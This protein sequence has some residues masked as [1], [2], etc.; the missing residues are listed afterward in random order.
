VTLHTPPTT[1][2]LGRMLSQW[3]EFTTSLRDEDIFEHLGTEEVVEA[4][5]GRSLLQEALDEGAEAEESAFYRRL[6]ISDRAFATHAPIV[7]QNTRLSLYHDDDPPQH[8]WWRVDELVLGDRSQ[9][10]YSVPE[11]AS[12]KGVHPHTVRAAVNSGALPARRLARGFLI[13]RRDLERWTPARRGRPRRRPDAEQPDA[14][15]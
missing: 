11:A 13:H 2:G 15:L 1:E 8:W 3:E 5:I 14:I 9:V 6:A 10:L 12:A 4:L 7:V